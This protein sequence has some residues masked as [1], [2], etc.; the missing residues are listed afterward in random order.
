MIMLNAGYRQ[1][2]FSPK[3]AEWNYNEIIMMMKIVAML[4]IMKIIT[5]IMMK[6]VMTMTTY[7]IPKLDSMSRIDVT[8]SQVPQVD[9]G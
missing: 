3:C 4:T 5:M 8:G 7:F 1:F 6:Y 9:P 2:S